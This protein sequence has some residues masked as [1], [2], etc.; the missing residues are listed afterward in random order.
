MSDTNSITN[1]L[2]LTDS[3]SGCAC[4]APSHSRVDVTAAP[5]T[6]VSQD[7]LV[8]GMTCSHCVGSVTEELT[9]LEGVE[10]VHVDLNAGGVSRVTVSSSGTLL[11]DDVRAAV[12]EAGYDLVTG[13]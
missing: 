5:M 4:C 9:A 1:D 11:L 8:S 13:A 6:A 12:A 2:S 7:F 10:A 3:N